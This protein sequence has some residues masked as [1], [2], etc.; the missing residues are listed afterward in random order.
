MLPESLDSIYSNAFYRNYI[1]EVIIPANVKYIGGYAF[2]DNDRLTSVTL[3]SGLTEVS[4]YCF[5]S[6]EKLTVV[7]GGE[8]VKTIGSGAFNYCSELRSVSD[9]APVT[10]GSSAFYYCKK[11]KISIS[12]MLKYSML[13]LIGN[14]IL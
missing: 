8:N 14:A 2:N 3:G 4:S 13:K 12:Q 6:C 10:V 11:W 9:L 7:K 5:N 1:A